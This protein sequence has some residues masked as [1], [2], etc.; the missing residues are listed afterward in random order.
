MVPNMSEE[1]GPDFI[2]VTDE[3]GNEFELEHL[4]TLEYNGQT[5]MA[6]FPAV[7]GKEDGSVEDV[8]LD[9]EYGLVILKV[10]EADGEEQ[11]STLDRS[12]QTARN[13][14]P[15]WTVRRSWSW[16]ISSLWSP[17]SRRRTARTHN[18]FLLGA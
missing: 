10:I 14:S 18:F 12:R 9:E 3:D 13:S 7:E 2:T 17:S 15:P 5:Y 11:L 4:D 8:D 1:F 6:F 16:C